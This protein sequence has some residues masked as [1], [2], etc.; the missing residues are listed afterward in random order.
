MLHHFVLYKFM[1]DIDI[2][3]MSQIENQAD[4]EGGMQ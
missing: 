2:D 3:R 4:A 1:T